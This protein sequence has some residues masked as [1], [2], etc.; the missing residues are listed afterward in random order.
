MRGRIEEMAQRLELTWA[1]SRDPLPPR[2]VEGGPFMGERGPQAVPG[3]W[4]TTLAVGLTTPTSVT[5]HADDGAPVSALRPPHGVV[6]TD[7]GG[8]A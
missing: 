7:G 8:A 5:A 1:R 4:P 2:K 6:C 3:M